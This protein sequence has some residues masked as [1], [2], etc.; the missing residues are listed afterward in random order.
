MQPDDRVTQRAR[1]IIPEPC[2]WDPVSPFLYQGPLE[3]WSNGTRRFETPISHGLRQFQL[4]PGGLLVNG[5]PCPIRAVERRQLSA[6][7]AG[8]LRQAGY[9]T[10]LA[11]VAAETAGLWE[12]ADRSGFLVLGRIDS[13]RAARAAMSVQTHPC[14]LGWILPPD[15]LAERAVQDLEKFPGAAFL[16]TEVDGAW[17]DQGLPGFQFVVSEEQFLPAASSVRLPVIVRAATAPAGSAPGMLGVIS[18]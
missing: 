17:P 11:P 7:D 15:L 8:R 5:R 16:G 4:R 18:G 12:A 6:D 1:V 9:N 14:S 13:P 3:L 10:L 2:L